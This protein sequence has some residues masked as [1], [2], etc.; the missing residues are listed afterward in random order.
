MAA[1]DQVSEDDLHVSSF[2][3]TSTVEAARG[4]DASSIPVSGTVRPEAPSVSSS[5][6]RGEGPEPLVEAPREY[7]V[8]DPSRDWSTCASCGRQARPSLIGARLGS[9]KARRRTRRF[10]VVFCRLGCP[11]TAAPA[12]PTVSLVGL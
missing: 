9:W 12:A 5:N 1:N 11:S 2:C 4:S 3:T 10:A 8:A 7:L 6:P